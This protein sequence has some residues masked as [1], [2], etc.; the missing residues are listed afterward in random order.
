MGFLE[1]RTSAVRST[2]LSRQLLLEYLSG[3]KRNGGG[4]GGGGVQGKE[5]E[6]KE[7]EGSPKRLR[8]RRGWAGPPGG[9]TISRPAGT[10]PCSGPKP[11]VTATV[12]TTGRA[13]PGPGYFHCVYNRQDWAWALLLPLYL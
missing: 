8:G 3:L 10:Q 6:K 1:W 5:R 11:L 13:G 4:G 9:S 7:E 12:F 2:P